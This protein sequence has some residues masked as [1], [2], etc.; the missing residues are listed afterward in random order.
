VIK[1][2]LKWF[3]EKYVL[4]RVSFYFVK[5]AFPLLLIFTCLV[6]AKIPFYY[7]GV[8]LAFVGL[9]LWTLFFMERWQVGVLRLCIY[10]AVPLVIYQGKLE[11]AAWMIPMANMIY[12]LSFGALAIFIVLTLK[13]TRRQKGFKATPMDFLILVIALVVPNL[14]DPR[15]QSFGMGLMAAKIIVMFFSFE[16]LV[17]ELRSRLNRLSIAM[18]AAWLL[19]A[20]RGIL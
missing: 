16:V 19:V 12:N 13:F 2:R 14:P 7:T 9:I 3:K 18:I 11:Q 1:G 8:S 17:G 15:I 20:V 6:P 5:L 4:I 10:L